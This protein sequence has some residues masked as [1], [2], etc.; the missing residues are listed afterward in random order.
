MIALECI[1]GPIGLVLQPV[2]CSLWTI[3]PS[4]ALDPEQG[5]VIQL[6]EASLAGCERGIGPRSSQR[7]LEAEMSDVNRVGPRP[8]AL[9]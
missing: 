9:R 6:H 2:R 5:R 4:P 8:A 3:R 7:R 1:I